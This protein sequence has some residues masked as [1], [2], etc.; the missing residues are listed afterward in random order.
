VD[1]YQHGERAG[2]AD[3]NIENRFSIC[4]V[5]RLACAEI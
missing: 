4:H 1:A 3:G 2:D 5:A